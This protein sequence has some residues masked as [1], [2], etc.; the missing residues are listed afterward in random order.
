MGAILASFERGLE[1]LLTANVSPAPAA[2]QT[3]LFLLTTMLVTGVSLFFFYSVD[4]PGAYTSVAT[5]GERN[6][7]GALLRGIHRHG[8]DL[9]LLVA[10][11]HLLRSIVTSRGE[12]GYTIAWLTGAGLLLFFAAQGVTGYL[13]PLDLRGE[14]ILRRLLNVFPFPESFVADFAASDTVS[15]S[16]LVY[17]VALHLIP[18]VVGA[19][20]LGAHLARQGQRPRLWPSKWLM[21]SFIVGLI[22]A[23]LMAPAS[24]LPQALFD[25]FPAEL[26]GD[27][28][29][30]WPVALMENPA[31]FWG[32]LVGIVAVA[33]IA[34]FLLRR[35]VKPVVT[36]DAHRC[37]GCRLCY[38]DC[39]KIAITMAPR[40]PEERHPWIAMIDP[41]I[42]Q[43]CAT[44]VGSCGFDALSLSS[45]PTDAIHA[46]RADVAGKTILY[47]C[48]TACGGLNPLA[49]EPSVAFI[50]LA[51]AGQL[52]PSWVTDDFARGAERIIVARCSTL[53]C[54][55]RDGALFV[56]ERLTHR[57]RPWPPRRRPM[58]RLTLVDMAPGQGEALRKALAMSPTEERV[59]TLRA[60]G[61][62]RSIIGALILAFM[63]AGS[64]LSLDRLGQEFA[65]PMAEA[66]SAW[67]AIRVEGFKPVTI[68]FTTDGNDVAS[69][70]LSPSRPLAPLSAYRRFP[71]PRGVATL[72]ATVTER[73][74]E[75]V[76]VA[77]RGAT[78]PGGILLFRFDAAREGLTLPP[79]LR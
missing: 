28:L 45:H 36:V 3:T 60:A 13:L 63:V 40:S 69:Y 6:V 42:C 51:C 30:L 55:G 33:G 37:V 54:R 34:P 75:P 47:G 38:E 24:S 78:T 52:S 72:T 17:V 23:A 65:I 8:A 25:R 48:V 58:G 73:G 61:D 70:D 71:L 26:T 57:R 59:E 29:L 39:P 41:T 7:F 31:T 62:G 56:E 68:T 10:F 19:M 46:D 64:A 21:L 20:L 74:S 50:P 14:A 49:D 27:P 44:C 35:P 2:G 12:K 4:W 22:V 18:P 9:L 11:W 1:R 76:S 67:G 66:G 5:L 15:G 16:A 43:G 77:W 79:V 32:T 53:R